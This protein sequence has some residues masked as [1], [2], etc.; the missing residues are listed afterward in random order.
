VWECRGG[1]RTA[2]SGGTLGLRSEDHVKDREE[3]G[4]EVDAEEEAF[5]TYV[6]MGYRGAYNRAVDR[7]SSNLTKRLEV[8]SEAASGEE[9]LEKAVDED[10]RLDEDWRRLEGSEMG[11]DWDLAGIL[12][13]SHWPS[14]ADGREILEGRREDRSFV[15]KGGMQKDQSRSMTGKATVRRRRERAEAVTRTAEGGGR[16]DGQE[17]P[18]RMRGRTGT[19]RRYPFYQVWEEWGM[20]LG[21]RGRVRG[22]IWWTCR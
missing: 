18:S 3:E 17:K 2:D 16:N 15:G 7:D 21:G 10:G 22:T 9:G 20:R 4:D 1:E 14:D 6:A 19:R 8:A 11:L 13:P 12:E 5:G